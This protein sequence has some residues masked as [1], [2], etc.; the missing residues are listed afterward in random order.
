MKSSGDGPLNAFVV[1]LA[2]GKRKGLRAPVVLFHNASDILQDVDL[3]SHSFAS[4][5]ACGLGRRR[6]NAL[7]PSQL[8]PDTRKHEAPGK[9]KWRGLLSS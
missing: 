2:E 1:K 4:C 9:I 3:P 5:R 8:T 7:S 6:N